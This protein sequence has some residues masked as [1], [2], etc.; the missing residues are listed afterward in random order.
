MRTSK[1]LIETFFLTRYS[2]REFR[3]ADVADEDLLGILEAASTAPSCFNEQPWRFVLA[4][5]KKFYDI[6]TPGNMEWCQNLK[7]F[8]LICSVPTYARN[9]RTNHWASFDC[10]TAWGYMTMEAAHRGYALHAMAGFDRGKARTLFD[11][12]EWQ[13]EAVIAFG[14]APHSEEEMSPRRPLEESIKRC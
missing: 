6:L 1:F 7:T 2:P 5:K 4:D 8:V 14:V 9:G 13:P 12:G 3:S 10:G 11:L